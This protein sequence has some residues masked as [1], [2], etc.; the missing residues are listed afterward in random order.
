MLSGGLDSS[1]VLAIAKRKGYDVTALSFNYGQRHSIEIQASKRIADHF[2]VR[3]VV[4][5]MDFSKIGG[6][7]LTADIPVEKRKVEEIGRD[8][9]TSY[10]PARNSIFLAIAAA[11]AETAGA[12]RIFIGANAVD[13]SGYP[14]CRPEFFAAFE[15]AI[16]LGTKVGNTGRIRIDVPLQFLSK[17]EIISIG[18]SLGVPYDLTYSC[19]NGGELPCGECDSCLLRLKGFMEAGIPDPLKYEKYPDF[20]KEFLKKIK[21]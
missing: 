5:E 2:N 4:F 13:Y 11:F 12:D 16:N 6:S 18:H 10:V 14:D 19:Y 9:P 15:N 3:H 1:T 20:Y 8:I 7:S 21:G 17:S